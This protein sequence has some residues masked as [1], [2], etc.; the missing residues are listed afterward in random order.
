MSDDSSGEKT[1]EPTDK[2]IRDAREKGQVAKSMDVSSTALLIVVFAFLS[3]VKFDYVQQTMEMIT[4]PSHYYNV[5]FEEALP[6][7]LQ[8]IFLKF[9][10]I[11]MPILGLVSIVGIAINFIQIGP[12]FTTE[13]LKP[14]LNKLNPINKAKELFKKKNL[15]EFLK[16]IIKVALLTYLLYKIIIWVID[17]LLKVPFAGLSA[18]FEILGPI[19]KT[20]CINISAAY[21]VIAVADLFFQRSQHIKDLKM[22]KDEV[23][24][25]FKEMEGDPHIKGER[26]ALAQELLM[27]DTVESTKKAS[28]LVTNPEHFAVAIYYDEKVVKLPVVTAKGK[29]HIAL[30]MIKVAQENNIPIMRDVNLA[31]ALY[32][33]VEK[34]NYVPSDLIEPVAAVLKWAKDL[35]EG[36]HQDV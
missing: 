2:K 8:G 15:I 32:A 25:E 9:I 33:D 24:R 31:R 35:Y 19:F 12:L 1:E 23:K 3:I 27:G 14:D 11:S 34:W 5:T 17:P 4:L 30:M 22:T 7:V 13:P 26:K 28:A 18:I 20:F 10:A 21:V 29:D 36:G 16:S 6:Q